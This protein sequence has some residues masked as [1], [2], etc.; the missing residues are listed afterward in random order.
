MLNVRYG[1]GWSRRQT[2]CAARPILFR[3]RQRNSSTP[4]SGVRRVP[5]T[6]LDKMRS[7]V[8]KI[9]P[10]RRE[11]HFHGKLVVLPQPV[12]FVRAQVVADECVEVAAAVTG[13]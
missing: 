3:S 1:S 4:S 10:F 5:L 13:V 12:Q 8:V 7:M 2:A 9:H 11:S 6:A